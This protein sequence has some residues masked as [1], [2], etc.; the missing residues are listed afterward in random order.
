M[1]TWKNQPYSLRMLYYPNVNT[2]MWVIVCQVS[3]AP[4]CLGV[5]H[6]LTHSHVTPHSLTP[7]S[8]QLTPSHLT[9]HNSL[10]H[11]SLLTPSHLTPSPSQLELTADS[12]PELLTGGT[13]SQT[14]LVVWAWEGEGEDGGRREEI[15]TLVDDYANFSF[16]WI[17][18]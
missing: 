2:N 14:V 8:S 17:N 5:D 13:L 15:G 6:S 12:L 10:P 3:N 7:H 9:P 18:W 1:S 11:T 16:A 4:F